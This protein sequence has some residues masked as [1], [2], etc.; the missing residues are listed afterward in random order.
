MN[1]DGHFG[2]GADIFLICFPLMQVIVD[3]LTTVDLTLVFG[4]I[5]IA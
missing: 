2:F 3:F 5:A 4:V 1:P